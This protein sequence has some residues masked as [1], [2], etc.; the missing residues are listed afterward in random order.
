[1]SALLRLEVIRL[2]RSP[3]FLMYLAAFPV[4]MYLMLVKVLDIGA[5]DPN[6]DPAAVMV[7]M[8]TYGSLGMALLA[9]GSI[10]TERHSGWT[11]QLAIT[12]LTTRAYV[13]AKTLSGL[14]VVPLALGLVLLAG[15]FVG[16]VRLDALQWLEIIV[17]VWLAA[18]PFAVLGVTIGYLA[19]GQAAQG[20]TV[21]LYFALAILGGLWW[22]TSL[23]PEGLRPFAEASPAYFAGSLG[24]DVV[25]GE[26]VNLTAIGGLAAWTVVFA[27]IAAWR[28]KRVAAAG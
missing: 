2:L 14:F 4:G 22:P 28:Y 16:E 1:M 24:W 8:A 15:A 12:P 25:D 3:Q 19:A 10:A 17:L 9:A 21:G 23:F 26:P 13:I 7:S 11:R 6:A 20:L 18:T 27:A 5:D